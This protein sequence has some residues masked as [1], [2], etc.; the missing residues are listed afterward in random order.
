MTLLEK[1]DLAAQLADGLARLD[2]AVLATQRQQLLGYLALLQKWNKVHNL[3]AIRAPE[4]MVA[5]HLLDSMSVIPHIPEGALL[6]LG[7]GGG[8]PG[9][10]VAI[11]DPGRA[12]VLL[13]SSQKKTAFLRQAVAELGL[14]NV[15]VVSARVESWRPG[16]TFEVITARAVCELAELV[17]WSSH[18]LAEHGLFAALKGVYP[19]DELSRLPAT[20]RLRAAIPLQVP[21]I[22]AARHLVLME[23]AQ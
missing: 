21:G 14:H 9:I 20:M 10:P 19:H 7:S 12:V 23:R 13:D 2:V 5:G 3:T 15:T 22:D 17:V 18:L 8:L 11:C 6:D 1:P 16:R 4:K